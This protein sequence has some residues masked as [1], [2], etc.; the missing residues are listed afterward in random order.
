MTF[1]VKHIILLL[2]LVA[3]FIAFASNEKEIS[4]FSYM[5]FKMVNGLILVTAEIDNMEG[6]FILDTGSEE[7]LLNGS[8]S[9]IDEYFETAHGSSSAEEIKI[10]TFKLGNLVKSNVKAYKTD[11]SN[12][13]AFV[14]TD[15]KGLIGWSVLQEALIMFDFD[16]QT[17][18]LLPQD[19]LVLENRLE[20]NQVDFQ[21]DSS[22]P[23]LKIKID[24]EYHLFALD[25]GATAHFIDPSM[26]KSGITLLKKDAIDTV[27]ANDVETSN[28]LLTVD[29]Y[30][31]GETHQYNQSFYSIDLAEVN[32]QF[33]R[34]LTGILSINKLAQSQL[35][36]DVKGQKIYYF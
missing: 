35:I 8:P 5:Q 25:S 11:L 7:V 29:S 16:N 26:V 3:P 36:I 31:I 13:S 4:I 23:I 2:L 10:K 17:L 28:D 30:S 33:D 24:K 21:I 6:T 12:L 19:V 9:K 32:K 1:K 15:L 27:L 34:P 14:N 22:I 18:K 20:L